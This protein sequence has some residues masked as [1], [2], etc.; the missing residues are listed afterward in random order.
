VIWQFRIAEGHD[1][2][3]LPDVIPNEGHAIEFRIN[4]EDPGRAFLPQAGPLT[5]F[6]EP[7]GPFVRVDAG[8]TAGGMISPEFDS[9]IAKIIVWGMD[10]DEALARG[11]QAMKECVIEGIPSLVP[12]HRRI[13]LEPAF[14]ANTVEDFTIHTGWIESECPWLPELKQALPAAVKRE[15]VIREWF[16]VDGRWVRLGFPARLLGSGARPTTAEKPA[17]AALHGAIKSP[18]NGILTRW[19]VPSGETVAV[20]ASLG[21]LEA[22]KMEMPILADRAGVFA[23]LVAENTIVK[24]HQVLAT[25]A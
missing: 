16:E 14:T 2:D 21:M 4:A 17:A 13:L 8:V 11:R 1:M 5:R 25:I 24:E 22:M 20:G 3:E 23:A 6:D 19:F 9:M 15:D 7:G 18:M 12:F 10:R